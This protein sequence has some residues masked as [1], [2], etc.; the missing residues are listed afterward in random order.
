MAQYQQVSLKRHCIS[1]R[2]RIPISIFL[3]KIENRFMDSRR[4]GFTRMEPARSRAATC[5]QVAADVQLSNR[6]IM[7]IIGNIENF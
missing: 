7:K 1:N 5:M 6:K 4:G 2:P 3:Q